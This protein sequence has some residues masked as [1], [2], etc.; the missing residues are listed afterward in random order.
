MPSRLRIR[1][2]YPV[3][4]GLLAVHGSSR[5]WS[6][7]K[8]GFVSMLA[9]GLVGGG[10]TAGVLLGTGAAGGGTTRT[11]IQTSSLG[12]SSSPTARGRGTGLTARQIY[13]RDAP[14]V[15]LVRA[16][17]L[18]TS[19][20]SLDLAERTDGVASAAGFVID[21]DGRLLTNAHVVAGATD[22]SVTF[23]E[24]QTVPARVLGKDEETDL[25]LLGVEPDGLDLQP[26]EL[27]TSSSVQVGDPTVSIGN[28]FGRDRTLT[29]GVV[30]A[31]QR[32]ITAPSG[33]SV[34]NVIQ[35]D[36][37]LAPGNA[38]GPLLDASGRVIGVNSQIATDGPQGEVGLGFAVPID[39]AKALIP[40]LQSLRN[41]S[42][43]YLGIS[44]ADEPGSL[45][46]LGNPGKAGVQVRKVDPDGP[47][48]RAGILGAGDM[49]AGDVILSVDG[50]AVRSM[51]DIDDI[52]S[53]H[54]PGD[55]I[56][57]VLARDGSRL[58]VQVQLS[59][60]PASVPLG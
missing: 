43:A 32:R 15:V 7:V 57:V 31:R 9:A 20:S 24:E 23:S 52:V 11:V 5:G 6:V 16:R 12:A 37:V 45:V 42:H 39:T 53:R 47:A 44:A 33:F 8:S 1:V 3:P 28:P 17:S 51:A 40:A 41:V 55:G 18:Q 19:A 38:G 10:V 36:G 21:E 48:A 25:A 60:R 49:A 54:R 22:V 27:G 26:L 50:Q 4:S 29:T 2:G 34:D 58:T 46:A 35:T 14:G 56:P 13:E 30:A 59:E